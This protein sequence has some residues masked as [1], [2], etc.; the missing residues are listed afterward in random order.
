[1]D[2]Y[3]NMRVK[4]RLEKKK[5]CCYAVRVGWPTL[6]VAFFKN[7]PACNLIGECVCGEVEQVIALLPGVIAFVFKPDQ[8]NSLSI[9]QIDALCQC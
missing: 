1:M 5:P 6:A 7:T 2:F 4:R 9:A 8:K 3:V